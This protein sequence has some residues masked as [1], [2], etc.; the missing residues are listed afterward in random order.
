MGFCL[1]LDHRGRRIGFNSKGSEGGHLAGLQ[2]NSRGGASKYL[3]KLL[4]FVAILCRFAES[5]DLFLRDL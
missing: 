2:P 3:V 1:S 4:Y 5:I